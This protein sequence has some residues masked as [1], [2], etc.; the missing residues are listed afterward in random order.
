[1]LKPNAKKVAAHATTDALVR[2][3]AASGRTIKKVDVGVAGGLKKKKF[4]RRSI[5]VKVEG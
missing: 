4:I 1:M 2:E 3:F 5:F